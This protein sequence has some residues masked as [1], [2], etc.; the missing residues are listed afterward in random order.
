M[1][2]LMGKMLQ[3]G[4]RTVLA[5]VVL[6]GIGAAAQASVPAA[7]PTGSEQTSQTNSTGTPIQLACHEYE[8]YEDACPKSVSG[9]R[10]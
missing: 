4:A 6:T 7:A 8:H 1:K 5:V 2:N 3:Q 9:T 10:G